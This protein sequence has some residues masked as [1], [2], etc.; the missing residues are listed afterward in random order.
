[1]AHQSELIAT[2]IEAYLA[3]HE[4]KDLLRL[5]TCGSVDDGKSTLIGRLL[6]DANMIYADHLAALEADSVTAGTTGDQVDLAL[7]MDGLK[8]EREQGI[9]I[10]VAYRYFST[11]RRKFIIADTPGHVQYTRNMVT[12]ASTAQLA[13]ILVDARHGVLDQTRRHSYIASLLGISHVVVAVNKMDLVDYDRDVFTRIADDYRAFAAGLDLPEPYVL[14]MSALVGDN[15]VQ[16]S[17][18]MD[19]FDGPPLMEH[20]ETVDVT[21]DEDLDRVRFPV[22]LVSRP[23]LDFRGFAGTVAAGVLRPGQEVVALPSGMHSRVERLV[24]FDG[25]L[26]AARPGQAV[27]VTLTDE[28]DLSRGDLLVDAAHPPARAHEVD[29]MLVWMADDEAVPGRQYLLLSTNGVSN[30]SLATITHRVDVNT[31]AHEPAEGL[32][33]NDVARVVLAADREL[34]FDPYAHNRTTGS[35][36]L[37]DRLTNLTVGAGMITGAASGWDRTPPPGLAQHRSSITSDERAARLGQ[38]PVTVLFTGMT[39]TGKSTLAAAVERRLFDRGRSAL[40]L[41]GENLR[42]G[43][44]R[45]LGFSN[46]DRSENLRRAAEIASLASRHGLITLVA[47]QAPQAPVR[48]RV[49]DLLGAERYLEVFLDAPEATRRARDPNGLYAAADRGELASLPGVSSDYDRPGA[50]DLALDTGELTLEACVEA[51]LDLLDERGFV[52]AR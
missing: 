1:M 5:L 16:P 22:Q 20:L 24:T 41:D 50:P 6:H 25:D 38:R 31:L 34:L 27:T 52:D 33:L 44:S 46:E 40:R 9:T 29:A 48:D 13:I 11:A 19:W 8:A 49:R 15:V 7:L 3:E 47:V 17:T 10:D 23:D 32:G 42:L 43:I 18:A 14:P 21:A 36:V 37:V 2:D 39:G 28:I 51:V 35:F 4:R 12:G 30:A 26:E 45:D